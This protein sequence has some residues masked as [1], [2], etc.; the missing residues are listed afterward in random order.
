M[1]C[2]LGGMQYW[3]SL[4]GI[5]TQDTDNTHLLTLAHYSAS[6]SLSALLFKKKK[7]SQLFAPG[8]EQGRFVTFSNIWSRY[9]ATF[10]EHLSCS[11]LYMGVT[12]AGAQMAPS[13]LYSCLA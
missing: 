8:H 9:S 7:K 11:C 12:Q 10:C 13:S 3:E 6:L 2:F 5:Q 4:S 1:A